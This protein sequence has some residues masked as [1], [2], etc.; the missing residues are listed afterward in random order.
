ML[1]G[2]H[3]IL[4][5]NDDGYTE[6][7]SPAFLFYIADISTLVRNV[8]PGFNHTLRKAVNQRLRK[9][10]RINYCDHCG[11]QQDDIEM[12]AEIGCVFF[13]A[14]KEQAA[15]IRLHRIDQPFV[16]YYEDISH[17]HYYFDPKGESW[18]CQTCDWFEWMTLIEVH[19]N[20]ILR[21]L[22]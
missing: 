21:L 14:S 13:P 3:K 22:H 9:Q 10:H 20:H 8:L 12:F 15:T 16:G 19:T 6:Q 17:H 5:N 18:I 4:E 1:L 11:A 2:E 7:G